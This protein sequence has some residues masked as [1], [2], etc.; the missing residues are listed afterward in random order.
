MNVF[1]LDVLARLME[2]GSLSRA[3][4]EL[5]VSQPTVTVRM[6]TLENELGVALIN[7]NGSK[8]TVTEA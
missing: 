1:H 3:A 2:H 8:L 6:K 4:K 5:G 7:R